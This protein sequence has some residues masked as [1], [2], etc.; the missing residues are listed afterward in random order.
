MLLAAV[1]TFFIGSLICAASTSILV[2]IIS[3]TIQGGAAGGLVILVNICVSDIF[4][5]R[6][7]GF[8]LGM[9][10]VVWALAAGVGPVLGGVFMERLSWRWCWWINLP[11]SGFAFGILV[12]YLDVGHSSVGWKEGV[13]RIDWFGSLAILGATVM[14][15]M[16]LDFGGVGF[17]WGSA[18]VIYLLVFSKL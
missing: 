14:F 13:K 7:R 12:F 11:C 16:G 6:E 2:L 17:P 10:S 18:K 5:L 1:F 8:W 15:L 4:E 9:T 3:R